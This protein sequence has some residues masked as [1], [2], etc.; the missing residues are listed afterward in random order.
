RA[1]GAGHMTRQGRIDVTQLE[2]ETII[3]AYPRERE[4]L[5][6]IYL[7][8][9][10]EYDFAPPASKDDLTLAIDYDAL[11]RD[12]AKLIQ[13]RRFKLLETL[14]VVAADHLLTHYPLTRV[15]VTVHKPSAMA[16]AAQ[17]SATLIKTAS[18]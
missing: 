5:Q 1:S 2:I 13:A 16:R 4:V 3:G 7:D 6:T 10:L 18:Q 15:E 17:I 9:G 12:L 11:T 14:T 8:L